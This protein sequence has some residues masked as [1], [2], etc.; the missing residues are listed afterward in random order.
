MERART[1]NLTVAA[2]V[3]Q[4][5]LADLYSRDDSAELRHNVMF[6]T[7]ALDGLLQAHLDPE[8]RP[9]ILKI[10]RERLAAEGLTHTAQN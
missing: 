7:I 4:L 3:R 1:R 9:R 6:Q 2:A 10:W 5:V 8:L